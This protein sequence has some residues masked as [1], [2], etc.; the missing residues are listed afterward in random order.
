MI[1]VS[2][3]RFK[4]TEP[5]TCLQVVQSF[6]MNFFMIREDLGF[7]GSLV[8]AWSSIS[9]VQESEQNA[10]IQIQPEERSD[11]KRTITSFLSSFETHS[12][13]RLRPDEEGRATPS[14]FPLR[15][16]SRGIQ[17]SAFKL[18]CPRAVLSK[19]TTQLRKEQKR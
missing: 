17:A 6:P 12:R 15:I 18:I 2:L 14:F 5:R 19:S 13:P 1:C 11:L 8:Y 4:G 7:Q 9:L 10:S 16:R 3:S